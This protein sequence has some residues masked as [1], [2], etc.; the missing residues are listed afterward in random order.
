MVR[1]SCCRI[2]SGVCHYLITQCLFLRH[3]HENV[4][5]EIDADVH[6]KNYVRFHIINYSR[7]QSIC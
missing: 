2:V 4:R 7:P 3:F 1:V 5:M 6:S